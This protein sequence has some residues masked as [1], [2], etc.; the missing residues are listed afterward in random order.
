[1]DPSVYITLIINI[2]FKLEKDRLIS[3]VSDNGIGRVAAAKINRPAKHQ[4]KAIEITK[5]RLDII[6]STSNENGHLKIID[7]YEAEQPSGTQ[8]ILPTPYKK[9]W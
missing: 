6:H 8:V 3:V 5:E 4:S 1:M 9:L 2:K 7:L